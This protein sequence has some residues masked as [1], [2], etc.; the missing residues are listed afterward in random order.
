M[1]IPWLAV[2][3][4]VPWSEVITN[5]PKVVDGAKKLWSSV[6]G[7]PVA[8]M[9]PAGNSDVTSAPEPASQA[10]AISTL[11]ARIAAMEAGMAEIHG[12]MLASTELI[13][14]LA[15]QNTQLV[16]HIEDNRMRIRWLGRATLVLGTVA[17][18]GLV[19]ALAR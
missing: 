7:K 9:P 6:S 15:E 2:L 4:I 5:A 19:L 3:K 11:K 17:V 14:S 13:Q 12:Q 1:P 10:E 8:Q 18:A 16:R